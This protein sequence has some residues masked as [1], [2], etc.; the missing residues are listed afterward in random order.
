MCQDFFCSHKIKTVQWNVR[1]KSIECLYRAMLMHRKVGETY[2]PCEHI[3]YHINWNWPF[4]LNHIHSDAFS[5]CNG[6]SR[7]HSRSQYQW[8]TINNNQSTAD[9]VITIC[10]SILFL[11]NY[12]INNWTGR[13]K[14]IIIHFRAYHLHTIH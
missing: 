4:P 11:C 10:R 2:L 3:D 1:L 8:R 13:C 9:V 7:W 6:F 5:I 12:V 14:S